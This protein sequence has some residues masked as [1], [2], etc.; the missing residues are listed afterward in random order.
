MAEPFHAGEMAI[1]Q[2]L[3][4]R[5]RLAELGPRI[6]RDF[7]PE[8]HRTFFA[9]LP[10]VVLGGVDGAGAVWATMLAGRPGFMQSPDERTLT[11]AAR[12]A[13]DDPFAGALVADGRIGLLGIEPHTRRRNRMNGRLTA[14]EAAGFTLAVEQSFG[15]C[16][17]YIHARRASFAGAP[18]N[19]PPAEP[20]EALDAPAV[21]QIG[22]ADTLF[23]ASH[24][25]GRAG[26]T[27][28][29]HRGGRPGFVKIEDER[30]LLVPDFAGNRF[31]MTLGNLQA[32][33]RAGVLFFDPA[34]G[35]LLQLSGRAEIVWDGTELTAFAGAERAWRLRLQ[36][37]ARR[38]AALP[39]RWEG[40]EASPFA[41]A[42]GSWGGGGLA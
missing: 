41:L 38:R 27:D 12:P 2:L 23:V 4:D 19:P 8:Q 11:L 24:A 31:F 14:L 37:G 32:D 9:K 39:L 29:S 34:R 13:A 30:T 21:A 3:G 17:K 22:A 20:L 40:S 5:A 18:A 26:G 1:Q 35:D 6:V 28:V 33:G 25:P 42:T 10:F 15:N 7:M 16:P 36:R